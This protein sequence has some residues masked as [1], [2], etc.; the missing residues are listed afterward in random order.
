[1]NAG[2]QVFLYPEELEHTSPT[3]LVELI[4][5]IGCDTAVVAVMYHRARRVFPRHRRVSVLNGSTL[6]LSPDEDR[7]QRIVPAGRAHDGLFRFRD[8]CRAAGLRFHAWVVGLHHELLASAHP[9]AG[10]RLL[11]GSPAGHSLCPSSPDAIA[12]VAA[13]AADVAAQLQPDAVDLEA[14]FYPAWEPS[15][16]LTLALEPLSARARLLGSQCFCAH[17]SAILGGA[18]ERRTRNAAGPPFSPSA[19][20]SPVDDGLIAELGSLRVSGAQSF[21]QEVGRAVHR[22][23]S[24][25]RVFCSG[26]LEQARLQ[27]VAPESVANADAVL[28][29]CGPLGDTDLFD[30]FNGL[31]ALVGRPGTVST[32]WTPARNTFATD[33]ERLAREGAEGVALYNLSLVPEEGIDA[34][35]AAATGFREAATPSW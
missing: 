21:I 19:D 17:C 25:L 16:T 29:G 20:E 35:R 8:E 3:E 26:S 34:F 10:A 23:G 13:L 6:Y 12:Y 31:R 7:Y 28:V 14:G 11:D 1:M 32:N 9:D 2:V 5:D 18:L 22:E 33:V 30:R 15:Y 24:A 4:R 27:G